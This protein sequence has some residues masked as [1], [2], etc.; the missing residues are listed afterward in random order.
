MKLSI[1]NLD[2]I[3]ISKEKKELLKIRNL[4]IIKE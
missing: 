3:A 4:K 1:I 2:D